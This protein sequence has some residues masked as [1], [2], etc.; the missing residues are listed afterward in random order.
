M[1]LW[2]WDGAVG[3]VPLLIPLPVPLLRAPDSSVVGWGAPSRGH[4]A[5][6]PPSPRFFC[7]P[8]QPSAVP[9]LQGCPR[10]ASV[11][12]SPLRT[13]QGCAKPSTS[14]RKAA[15]GSEIRCGGRRSPSSV[16]ER[17]FST[18]Q[19]GCGL[20]PC[21]GL[22]RWVQKAGIWEPA[23]CELHPGAMGHPAAPNPLYSPSP[24][25][26]GVGDEQWGMM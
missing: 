21:P 16:L 6:V 1:G 8:G 11:L 20:L 13:K 25:G 4:Q 26:S 17:A 22:R 24:Q 5:A 12:A 7:H 18:A 15:A 23:R 19:R 3:L 14:S 10:A 2:G 9:S